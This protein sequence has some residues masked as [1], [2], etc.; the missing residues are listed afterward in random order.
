MPG[1][2]R[3]EFDLPR[4]KVVDAKTGV[5]FGTAS[6]KQLPAVPM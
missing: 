4:G 2:G 3:R 6:D 5:L 1:I